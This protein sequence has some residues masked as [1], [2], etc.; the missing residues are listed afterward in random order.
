MQRAQRAWGARVAGMSWKQAAEVAGY[1]DASTA[2]RGVRRFFGELPDLD[3]EDQRRLWRDRLD[4]LWARG[5]SELQNGHS[6][7]T[8]IRSLVSVAD[9][10][11]KLDGLDA[12]TR[13]RVGPDSD[14][15]EEYV[16]TIVAL[17]GRAVPIEG[18]PWA[19][20][21]DADVIEAD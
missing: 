3:M 14:E 18:D 9:R 20:V 16:R 10:A 15:L 2:C 12:P 1:A 13:L 21:V 4:V 6:A 17:S 11:A 5:H 7:A 19:D 8:I